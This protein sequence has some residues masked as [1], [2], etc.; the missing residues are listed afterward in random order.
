MKKRRIILI[1]I[2]LNLFSFHPLTAYAGTVETPSEI[3][4]NFDLLT[5][6]QRAEGFERLELESLLTATTLTTERQQQAADYFKAKEDD[7]ARAALDSNILTQEQHQLL[8]QITKQPELQIRLAQNADEF[9]LLAQLTAIDYKLGDDRI[10][11]ANSYFAQALK[12]GR[13]PEHLEAYALFSQKNQLLEQAEQ[14]YTEALSQRKKNTHQIKDKYF[15]IRSLNELGTIKKDRKQLDAAF[16]L[17]TEAL[18]LNQSLLAEDSEAVIGISVVLS[19]L[20]ELA[21]LDSKRNVEVA[22]LYAETITRLRPLAKNS[23]TEYLPILA[24]LENTLA[25]LLNTMQPTTK[26]LQEI[27]QNYT[28]ALSSYRQLAETDANSHLPSVA[29]VLNNLAGFLL[30]KSASTR[31]PEIEKYL[32]ESLKISQQTSTT[33]PDPYLRTVYQADVIRTLELLGRAHLTWKES[34]KAQTYLQ[35][36]L[37]IAGDKPEYQYQVSS[38]KQ[39]LNTAQ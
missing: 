38:I 25:G 18:A 17:Y 15:L 27:E 19:S 36:A 1:I 3:L 5:E 39:T 37:Q 35:E 28:E 23:P 2:A 6:Q 9:F 7:K 10:N 31:R 33:H 20:S 24:Q 26:Q 11:K 22:K 29:M 30:E 16:S 8:I 12:S 21:I 13:N 34:G 14:L 4:P 32:A